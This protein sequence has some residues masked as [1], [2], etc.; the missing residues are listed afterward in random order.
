MDSSY[1]IRQMQNDDLGELSSVYVRAFDDPQLKEDWSAAAA[2]ALLLDWFKRQPDLAF[3][4]EIDHKPVGGFIVGV[5]PWWD[6][7]HL[8]DGELFIDPEHQ[9]QGLASELIR[10]TLLTANEKYSPVLWE[11]YTF[12]GQD[13]PLKWY[14]KLGFNEIEDWVMIRANVSQILENL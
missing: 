7:N 12:R 11:T 1:R 9:G 14:K 10:Q 3:V 2:E 5:R 4:V 13:F 6:G 8:V